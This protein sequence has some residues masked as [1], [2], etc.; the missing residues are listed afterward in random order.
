MP[1]PAMAQDRSENVI[2]GLCR[3]GAVA[4][5]VLLI[6]CVEMVVQITFLGGQPSSAAEAF[7]LLQTNRIVGL[8]RLDLP[9]V[10]ALPFYYFLFLAFSA[11]LWRI[12]AV[13]SIISAL[14]VFA[15]VTLVLATPMGLSMVSLSA[16]YAAA[17]TEAAR[18][19]FLAAGE[20][21]L[22][23]DMW[24]GT[25]AYVG[26]LMVQWGAVLIC[27]AMVRSTLFGKVTSWLGVA[28]HG[29]DLLHLIL[30]IDLPK[31]GGILMAVA[32]PLYPV[33]FFLVGRDLLRIGRKGPNSMP[34]EP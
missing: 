22:A 33:W 20:V 21:I 11:V 17:T 1:T 14:L 8:L 7:H 2:L 18:N 4:A 24:H 27:M 28:V 9:T 16:K 6:Y 34:K 25:G 3:I 23:S 15:G 13:K 29:I 30:G 32:G 31:V 19:Q 12:D 26:G 10:V 5:F